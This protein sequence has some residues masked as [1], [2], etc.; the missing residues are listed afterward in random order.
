MID[1]PL[2]LGDVVA[3]AVRIYGARI[4]AALGLGAVVGAAFLV[5]AVTPRG[6]GIAAVSLAITLAYAA[7]ARLVSGDRFLEAWAQ[8]GLRLPVLLVL[9]LI[10]SLPFAVA[11]S[12]LILLL[13]GAAWLALVGF[14]IPVA[15]LEP[16]GLGHAL[17]RSLT[18]A[19][20]EYLHA[21]GVTAALLVIVL[22]V[23]IILAGALVAFAENERIGAVVL[24]QVVLSPLFFL[25]LAVLYFEQSARAL[26]SPR[27]T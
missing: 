24:T 12:Y 5:V 14:S 13:A 7:A 18:L 10:V 9:T 26:S 11:V 25:G 20:A 21:L 23:G 3:E 27:R 17:R 16:G 22:L 19:R 2:A 6:V 4:W 15:V 8:V 1:R